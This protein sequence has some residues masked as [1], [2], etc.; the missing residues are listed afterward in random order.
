MVGRGGCC[1]KTRCYQHS[2]LS[3]QEM[4][5]PVPGLWD[6]RGPQVTH[7]ENLGGQAKIVR[8]FCWGT[9]ILFETPWVPREGL[10]GSSLDPCYTK[11][12]FSVSGKLV[13]NTIFQPHARP[14]ESTF[15][16]G[17]RNHMGPRSTSRR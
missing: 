14:G 7:V 6:F 3:T 4:W 1:D 16:A 5:S 17:P 8:L 9:V 13:G 2:R 15:G 10:L 12:S 11:C